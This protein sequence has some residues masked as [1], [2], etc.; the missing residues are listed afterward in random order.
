MITYRIM[1]DTKRLFSLAL[2]AFLI[3]SAVAAQDQGGS[4]PAAG[5]GS[6]NLTVLKSVYGPD[7]L[8]LRKKTLESIREAAGG[9][10]TG[11]DIYAALEYMSM[12]GLKNKTLSEKG[13][14]LNNY[15][16]IRLATAVQLGK[17]GT[18][19]AATILLQICASETDLYVLR[20]TIK[21]LGDIGYNDN[22]NT[23]KTILWKVQGYNQR[24]PDNAVESVI[25]SSIDAFE[26]IDKKN[27]GIKNNGI[28]K[29]V[30]EFLERVSKNENVSRWRGEGRI[31]IQERAKSVREELS[32]RESERKS[33]GT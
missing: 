11:D 15:P 7:G 13:H 32:R 26:K 20:E 2:A 3:V 19:K 23:V 14:I 27:D 16:D 29:N 10:N 4:P 24:T 1:T 5:Q 28:F 21:A 33:Q 25:L 31:S 8:E 12:E 22:D 6:L 9:E 18:E 30:L 17:L